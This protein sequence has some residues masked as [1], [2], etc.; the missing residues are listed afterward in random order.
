MNSP[1]RI[2]TGIERCGNPGTAVF[3]FAHYHLPQAH[4]LVNVGV[5]YH[6]LRSLMLLVSLTVFQIKNGIDLRGGPVF[7]IDKEIINAQQPLEICKN[8][9]QQRI[10]INGKVK[11]LRKLAQHIQL[12]D[13]GFQPPDHVGPLQANQ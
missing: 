9:L 11:R 13:P 5:R 6:L 12:R 4:H 10:K 2:G 8:Q 1:K 7:K 3:I